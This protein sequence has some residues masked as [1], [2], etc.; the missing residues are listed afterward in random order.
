MT[1][2]LNALLMAL[3]I[4]I[5]AGCAAENAAPAPVSFTKAGLTI[6]LTDDFT[7]KEHVSYTAVYES[8]DIAV[9]ALK[10]E[11]GLFDASVLNADS[12]VEVYAD[13][14]WKANG[15]SE[16]LTLN[17]TD[18]M[19][20]F[21]YDRSVNGGDYTYCVYVFKG[22][23]GFWLVQFTVFAEEF[24]ALESTIHGY[25]KTIIIE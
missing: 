20:W 13:L 25:A 14:V 15:F 1:R 6:T 21:R 22:S 11:F 3:T 7:E 23:D 12:S 19:H 8:A 18:G 2:K 10:E 4:L 9:F 24:T 5:L 17:N 16:P